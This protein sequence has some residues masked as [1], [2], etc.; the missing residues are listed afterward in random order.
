MTL[1]GCRRFAVWFSDY[2]AASPHFR[3]DLRALVEAPRLNLPAVADLFGQHDAEFGELLRSEFNELPSYVPWAVLR[4][5]LDAMD[6]GVDFEMESVAP[7]TPI[8]DARRRRVRVTTNLEA[9]RVV[10]SLSHVP[11][12]HPVLV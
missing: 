6:S 3:R 8:E 9:D 1:S 12:R 4:A 5:W 7:E 10:V 11:S 2:Q